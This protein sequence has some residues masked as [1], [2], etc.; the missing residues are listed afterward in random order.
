[1]S[2]IKNKILISKSDDDGSQLSKNHLIQEYSDVKKY[3][4]SKIKNKI[5]ISKSHD[6]NNQ[7]SKN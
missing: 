6:A 7:L 1:M 4:M 3:L 5:L 2:K